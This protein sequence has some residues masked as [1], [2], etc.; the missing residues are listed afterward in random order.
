MF[1]Y[2]ATRN[3]KELE[4]TLKGKR[5]IPLERRHPYNQRNGKKRIKQETNNVD[6]RENTFVCALLQIVC[7]LKESK[8]SL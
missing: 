6:T 4:H 8:Q 3:K 2:S 1:P 7:C 5:K